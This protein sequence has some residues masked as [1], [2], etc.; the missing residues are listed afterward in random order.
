MRNL[1][2]CVLSGSPRDSD[3]QDGCK[4]QTVLLRHL[5]HNGMRDGQEF[6]LDGSGKQGSR[7]ERIEHI[8]RLVS[9]G[10]E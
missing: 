1:A 6:D 7:W 10:D 2:I 5:A 8:Y 4:Q 3:V 9:G